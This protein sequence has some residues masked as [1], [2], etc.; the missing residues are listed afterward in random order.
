MNSVVDVPR[1]CI[2]NAEKL[3]HMNLVIVITNRF[4]TFGQCRVL[5]QLYVFLLH[6][7]MRENHC[8]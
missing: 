1:T 6:S 2:L 5:D 8:V 4:L 3:P 7:H